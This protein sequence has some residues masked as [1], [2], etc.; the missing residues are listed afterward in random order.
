LNMFISGTEYGDGNL[1]PKGMALFF[2][3]H[4]C[5]DICRSLG[6]TKFDLTNSEISLSRQHSESS[7]PNYLLLA[8]TRVRGNEVICESPG[9]AGDFFPAR[10]K[11]ISE[12]GDCLSP[13]RLRKMSSDYFSMESHE[14]PPSTAVGFFSSSV[15][16]LLC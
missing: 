9:A 2:H 14:S 10:L 3:S 1:G 6:L 8:A 4:Q 7:I 11:S 16:D 12:A 15:I 13:R 5:N